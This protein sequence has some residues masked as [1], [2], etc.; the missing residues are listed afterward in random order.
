MFLW[1]VL[2]AC[3]LQDYGVSHVDELFLMF[4]FAQ[5][6]NSWLGDLALQTDDDI[7]MARKLVQL[8]TNFAKHGRPTEG[9]E[10]FTN[11]IIKFIYF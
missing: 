5:V 7:R 11:L 10:N 3:V 8:W 2:I 1:V 9:N 4:K 6:S